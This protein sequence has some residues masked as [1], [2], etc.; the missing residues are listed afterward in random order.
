MITDKYD[1]STFARIGL[2]LFWLRQVMF[3]GATA[4]T[5]AYLS[6]AIPVVCYLACQVPELIEAYL[7]RR[8]LDE[9][10][11]SQRKIE[12][13]IVAE[14]LTGACSA[15]TVSTFG[16]VV[17]QLGEPE[18][19]F[20]P[21]M[22]VFAAALYCTMFNHQIMAVLRARLVIYVA[23]LL[24]LTGLD[25]VAEDPADRFMSF[26][27]LFT[28]TSAS[29]F[30]VM[31]AIEFRKN[32]RDLRQREFEV[33]EREGQLRCEMEERRNAEV[34][35]Q[36]SE[37]RFRSLFENAPI[38]IREEDLSGMKRRIDELGIE[39]PSEFSA[40]LEGHPE[41]LEACSK[42]IVVVDANRASLDQHG[43]SDK[44]EMLAK[45]VRALS[46]AAM[47]IVRKTLETI[48]SGA[49]GRSYE[50]TITRANGDVR[51]VAATWSVVPGH[52]ET[53]ARILLCSVDLT[54]WL[55]SEAALR[56]AQKME[57]VGQLTGGVAH[58]F[59]N[60]LTVISG[61]M[62][63]MEVTGQ[64]DRELAD[65]VQK[66]VRRG[67]E[68][69]QRLLAFSRKQPLSARSIDL[70]D[71]IVGMKDLLQRS[72]GE[73]I[74]INVDVPNDLWP[75]HADSG[76]VEAA[77]L[78][79]VL[80]SRDAMLGGGT[81]TISC[82]NQLVGDG[83]GTD[84]NDGEYVALSVSD[85]GQGM[86]PDDVHRAFEP[87][88]TTKDVGKGSGLGL[89][90]IYGF[91]KQ[92]GGTLT[93]ESTL[94]E[95]TNVSLLLPRSDASQ[96]DTVSSAPPAIVPKGSGQAILILEDDEGVRTYLSN[97]MRS[98]GYHAFPA[99]D[100]M[101]ARK[102]IGSVDAIDLLISDIMLPGGLLGP[103][104]A[105]EL[106]S[107]HPGTPVIFVSGR[108]AEIEKA[109]SRRVRD[110]AVLAKPFTATEISERV[111]EALR[112]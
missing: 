59:N 61:N 31:N 39:D 6:S 89:S 28:V 80:N 7:G 105:A 103:D 60:L 93:I 11:L 47:M 111:A 58:D 79:L 75:V 51:T 86:L 62:D 87:F 12:R 10:D 14:T 69:T 54:D 81:L 36:S 23:G 37:T 20:V 48:H 98:L 96:T 34:A 70:G 2:K 68:L 63:L 85:T 107:Y 97:L 43:Y 3:I 46:P 95:G 25:M 78:N 57:A 33:S 4:V 8:I 76:Q 16:I 91:A 100:A 32:Y 67:A 109:K 45:V 24:I 53:Y 64:F 108:P 42:E 41:F 99:R 1:L 30:C 102:I 90:M 22:Y 84:V 38:P 72:L 13:Y 83:D 71:L 44:S 88:F 50:T 17:A 56:Q 94:G 40:Y 35:R 55:A 65:P 104:F 101:A 19:V 27:Q 18:F 112:S 21:L 29:F 15:V 5:S 26:V 92:S 9:C 52:E 73:E 74:A 106:L 110:V 82:R 49:N 77:L 66:A